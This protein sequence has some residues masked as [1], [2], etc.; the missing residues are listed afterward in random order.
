MKRILPLV[1]ILIIL[2]TAALDAAAAS[3]PPENDVK[4]VLQKVSPSIVKVTAENHKRY[5]ATGIAIAP[6]MVISSMMVTRFPYDRLYITTVNGDQYPAQVLGK[7][8]ETSLLLLKID[9]KAL[10]PVRKAETVE[11]GD[12][13]ALVG[14]FYGRFPAVYQG[15]VSSVSNEQLILNAPVAPGSAGGA[16]VNQKGELVGVIRGRF[17]YAFSPD[18]I[19]RDH[20]A[21]FSIRSSRSRDKDLCYAIPLPRVLSVTDDLGKYGKVKRGWLGVSLEAASIAGLPVISDV[22]EDSPAEA[23]GVRPGDIIL[24]IGGKSVRSGSE[25]AQLV[26][27]L[28][29]GQK[30]K[31]EFQ[32]DNIKKSA[33]AV[34]GESKGP[35][36]QHFTLSPGRNLVVIPE[37]SGELPNIQNYTFSFTGSRSLGVDVMTMTRQL[38]G[39]FNVKEGT[40]LLISRVYEDTAA[41]KAGLE[42]ADVIVKAGGKEVKRLADLRNA[43]GDLEDEGPITLEIYRKGK[44][45]TIS[46]VPDKNVYSAFGMFDKLKNKMSEIRVNVDEENRLTVEEARKKHADQTQQIRESELKKYKEEL[47]RMKKEQEDLK[48]RMEQMMKVIKEKEKEK[49]TK[50]DKQKTSV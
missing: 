43:L 3:P 46:L 29:P 19:Y 27:A 42:P 16:V 14:L 45:K 36:I 10:T 41:A 49:E 5:V 13:T 17:G 8:G 28:K 24:G 20:S 31:I 40:G 30:T 34:I 35:V 50:K 32:R 6:E 12:W 37:I 33:I 21:E 2:A 18:Y 25:A 26:R 4:W 7:D 23:A 11:V 15:I 44:L 48:K 38:A 9:K 22:A 39:K 1:I 47:D